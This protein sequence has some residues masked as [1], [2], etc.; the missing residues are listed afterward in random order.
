M[1]LAARRTGVALSLI[2]FAAALLACGSEAVELP[3]PRAAA[4]PTPALP[5]VYP[6]REPLAPP[7]AQPAPPPP[8]PT[9]PL[10]PTASALAAYR[11]WMEEARAVH[12]Y[13]EPVEKMWAVMLCESSGNAAIVAGLHHG[14]FQYSAATWGGAWNPYRDQPILDPRAQIFATAKAW[15]DGHQSWWGCY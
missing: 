9:Q 6:T 7:A 3:A 11:A 8:A 10:D 4:V 15:Q 12:L 5:D 2:G 1:M 13:A 14:L